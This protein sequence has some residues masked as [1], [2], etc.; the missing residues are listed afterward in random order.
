M[1]PPKRSPR[2]PRP[3]SLIASEH[4]RQR[5]WAASWALLALGLLAGAV[6]LLAPRA[7]ADVTPRALL[8]N[9]VVALPDPGRLGGVVAVFARPLSERVPAP[10]GFGCRIVQPGGGAGARLTQ[11]DLHQLDRLVLEGVA[12]AAVLRVEGHSR[13]RSITCVGPTAYEAQPMYLVARPGVDPM[14]PMAAFSAMSLLLV[15]ATRRLPIRSASSP[16]SAPPPT[17]GRRPSRP[18]CARG[19]R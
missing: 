19:T 4:L 16:P 10:D 15:T 11:D 2:R 18:V 8:P 9:T 6:G 17:S 7:S 12:V 1:Q 14:A 13:G 5:W 3:R